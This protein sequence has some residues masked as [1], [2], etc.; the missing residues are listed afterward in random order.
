MNASDL[1]LVLRPTIGS[2]RNEPKEK[3]MTLS[4]DLSPDGV[5]E[6]LAAALVAAVDAASQYLVDEDVSGLSDNI[7]QALQFDQVAGTIAH[8][9][10]DAMGTASSLSPE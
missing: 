8:D 6:V 3:K 1:D 5:P 2:I 4:E 9:L 10:L 7:Q